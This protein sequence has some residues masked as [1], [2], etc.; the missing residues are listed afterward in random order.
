MY[1]EVILFTNDNSIIRDGQKYAGEAVVSHTEILLA[2]P[3]L[4]G[5]W[6]QKADLL[7]LTKGLEMR[8]DK[9]PR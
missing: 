3:F 8:K 9:K 2:E 1:A 5:I 6:A 7:A 4:A